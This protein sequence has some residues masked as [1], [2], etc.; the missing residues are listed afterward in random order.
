M[1]IKGYLFETQQQCQTA[2]DLINQSLGLPN[3]KHDSHSHPE[4]NG[5]KWFIVEDQYT[6]PLLGEGIEFELIQPKREL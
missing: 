4:L 2:I 5:D 1:I 6:M 3:D